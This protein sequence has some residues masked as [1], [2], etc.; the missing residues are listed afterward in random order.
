MEKALK[1]TI[2]AEKYGLSLKSFFKDYFKYWEDIYL[3]PFDHIL[4]VKKYIFDYIKSSCS[5]DFVCSKLQSCHGHQFLQFIELMYQF[6][7]YSVLKKKVYFKY[8]MF[9][10]FKLTSDAAMT[11]KP[12]KIKSW[13]VTGVF[14]QQL[15]HLTYSERLSFL[16]NKK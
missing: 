9:S 14:E 11:L 15:D 8:F 10:N 3:I 7:R 1:N 5:N 13:R 4:H 16:V 6:Q 2:I 12:T